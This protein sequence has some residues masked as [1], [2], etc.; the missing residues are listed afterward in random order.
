[1]PSS[2]GRG[3]GQREADGG[4]HERRAA[5]GGDDGGQHAGKE[6]AGMAGPLGERGTDAGD[7]YA[8]GKHPGQAEADSEHQIGDGQD[9]QR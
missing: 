9:E 8:Y 2:A 7:R 4:G 1:M 5:G 6:T 3:L